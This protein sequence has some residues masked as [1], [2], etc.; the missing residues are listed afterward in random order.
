MKEQRAFFRLKE[1]SYWLNRISSNAAS[2]WKLWNDLDILMRKSDDDS[3]PSN[4]DARLAYNFSAFFEDKITKIRIEMN[5]APPVDFTTCTGSTFSSFRQL[6]IQDVED[7]IANALNKHCAL[8]PMLT[9]V[10]KKCSSL[11]APYIQIVFN[12]S[13]VESYVPA[14]QKAALFKPLLKRRSIDKEDTKNYRP[15]SN[16]TF[17]SKLLERAVCEQLTE[18][19]DATNDLPLLQSAH[20]KFHSTESALLR[21]YSDLC[22]AMDRDHVSLL[23]LLNLSAAFDTV[24]FSILLEGL[25]QSNGIVGS[26]LDWIR[27]YLENRVQNVVMNQACSSTHHLTCEVPQGSVLEPLLFVMY[28]KDV[29]TII[30]RHGLLN[31]CYAD[32]TQIYFYCKL[33]D[34][35]SLAQ[36][37]AACT[38]ELC[39]L[40]KSKE[41]N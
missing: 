30:Q 35:G 15:V 37:F 40:I 39:T 33:E 5:T 7:L 25:E 6:S 19:L 13:I 10:V 31:H 36:T 26:M 11:L 17:L 27:S 29:T 8:N 3:T 18:F 14:S 1:Q 16:L 34:A 22:M 2:S 20:R 21:V 28:T 41:T 23:R 38:E 4:D 32:D 9:S 24:N 12:R